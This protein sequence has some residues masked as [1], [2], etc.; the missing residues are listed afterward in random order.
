MYRQSTLALCFLSA[1]AW[2]I[3]AAAGQSTSDEFWP[4]LGIYMQQ[5]PLI[6]IEFVASA[7]SDP[8][9]HTWR[10]DFTLYVEAALKPVFRRELRNQPDVYRNRYVT[11]RSGYRYRTSLTNGDTG[12]E[13]RGI[14]E[15]TPP[16]SSARAARDFRSQPGRVPLH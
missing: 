1:V 13:N 5:G 2:S 16:I 11:F 3:P 8:T 7:G 4:E 9:A 6:R 10:G 14:V 15:L 12:T